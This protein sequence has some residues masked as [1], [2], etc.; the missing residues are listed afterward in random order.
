[1][2]SDTIRARLIA[3]GIVGATVADGA[4]WVCLVGGLSDRVRAPQ[5]GIS[6]T[7]GYMPLDTMEGPDVRRAGIQVLV[8]GDAGGYANAAVMA[9]AV[10]DALHTARIDPIM[11]LRGMSGPTWVGY[12]SDEQRPVWSLNFVAFTTD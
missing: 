4:A 12:T 5:I 9:K 1:M 2:T 8:R 3:G 11:C 10:W 7:A 6:D